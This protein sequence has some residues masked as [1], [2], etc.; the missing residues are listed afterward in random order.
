[1]RTSGTIAFYNL[2]K[3][4]GFIRPDAGG[5]DVF[6]HATAVE[7]SDIPGLGEGDRVSFVVEADKQ[8][9]KPR[10]VDLRKA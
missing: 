4:Y 9:R 5:S 8:N 3:G 1:M 10:A 6:V 7:A 2:S